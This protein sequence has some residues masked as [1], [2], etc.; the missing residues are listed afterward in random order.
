MTGGTHVVLGAQ[1]PRGRALGVDGQD[2]ADGVEVVVAFV[3]G[4][5]CVLL[6][7]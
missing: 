7:H 1:R 3:L 2:V 6:F 4:V 5:Y